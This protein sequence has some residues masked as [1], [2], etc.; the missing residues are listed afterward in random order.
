MHHTQ[1]DGSVKSYPI[2]KL[3]ITIGS[4]E[5][6][7]VS[8][9][10]PRL[11]EEHARIFVR[12]KQLHLADL[13]SQWGTIIAGKNQS[14]SKLR[15]NEK[16]QLGDSVFHISRSDK[17]KIPSE[18]KAMSISEI[19]AFF[20]TGSEEKP[21][22]VSITPRTRPAPQAESSI[23]IKQDLLQYHKVDPGSGRSILS[24]DFSQYG[25]AMRMI[26]IAALLALAIGAFY[27]F[28]WIGT[29]AVSDS[30]ETE[31]EIWSEELEED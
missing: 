16:F 13:N 10:A 2:H 30:Y 27:L 23:K 12:D 22:K 11:S 25:G 8:I 5:E 29:Q 26:I 1:E 31:E 4:G 6:A 20:K 21:Q 24:H 9:Q 17:A 7:D 3:P 14:F 19:E 18:P 15:L 28:Q